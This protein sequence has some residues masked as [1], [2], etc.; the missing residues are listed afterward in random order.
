MMIESL[1]VMHRRGGF[2]IRGDGEQIVF[3]L[4]RTYGPGIGAAVSG[5]LAGIVILN[6]T[7][8]LLFSQTGVGLVILLSGICILAV[9]ALYLGVYF[10]RKRAHP[11]DVPLRYV[12]DL[13][14]GSLKDAKGNTLARLRDVSFSCSN[15]F[16]T[17]IY[18]LY[19]IF[20]PKRRILVYGEWVPGFSSSHVK[21]VKDELA[22]KIA[23][24]K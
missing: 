22:Q 19:V 9:F 23:A 12:L 4:R 24:F 15:N 3:I 21:G 17:R 1:P 16:F 5:G 20:P 11:D 13:S 6:G 2:E 8:Q 14:A 7:L 18:G 10:K